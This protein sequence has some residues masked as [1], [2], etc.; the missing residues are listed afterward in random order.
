MGEREWSPYSRNVRRTAY[1]MVSDIETD[2]AQDYGSPWLFQHRADLRA[3][4]LRLATA[5]SQELGLRGMPAKVR[6]GAK[7]VDVDVEAETVTLEGGEKL[8]ADLVIGE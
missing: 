5:R 2:Y 4:F 7:A 1:E 8:D 3:V 6:Y